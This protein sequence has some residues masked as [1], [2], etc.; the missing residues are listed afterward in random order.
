MELAPGVFDPLTNLRELRLNGNKL[1]TLPTGIF[2]ALLMLQIRYVDG[3]EKLPCLP[4]KLQDL[5]AL[6]TYHGPGQQCALCAPGEDEDTPGCKC[7]RGFAGA[8]GG[9]C[10]A[11]AVGKFKGTTGSA[12]CAECPADT[13][14]PPASTSSEA[15]TSTKEVGG[16]VVKMTF[17]LP[18][19]LGDFDASKKLQFR[20]ALA[21]AVGASSEHVTIDRVASAA[22]KRLRRLL[23]EG[24]HIET[25]VRVWD[26]SKAQAL[27]SNPPLADLN[28]QLALVGLPPAAVVEDAGEG[29]DRVTQGAD[30]APP[31]PESSDRTAAVVGGSLAAA[32]VLLC[33]VAGDG[34]DQP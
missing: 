31:P 10:A 15:C 32:S 20:S 27:R 17:A 18:V 2:D 34:T 28:R 25:S 6:T 29:G 21:S 3:T 19:S 23:A 33:L 13:T 22:A 24:V 4:Y 26:W 9:A 14:S 12:A 30:G 1:A 5:P 11:C 7:P 8:D 16:H